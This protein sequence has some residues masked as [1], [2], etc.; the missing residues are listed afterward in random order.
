[1]EMPDSINQDIA[2]LT[3]NRSK[4]GQCLYFHNFFQPLLV[5]VNDNY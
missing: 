5:P 3:R 1:M 4:P 2:S